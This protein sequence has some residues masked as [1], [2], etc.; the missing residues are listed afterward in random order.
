MIIIK[1]ILI[2]PNNN[3]YYLLI[4]LTINIKI[5]VLHSSIAFAAPASTDAQQLKTLDWKFMYLVLQ[6][7]SFHQLLCDW[8]LFILHSNHLS[9]LVN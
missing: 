9:I 8:I 6:R 2:L 1:I 3:I 7:F 4:I 5:E